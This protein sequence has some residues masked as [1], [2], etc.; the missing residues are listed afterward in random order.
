VTQHQTADAIPQILRAALVPSR[1]QLFFT[2]ICRLLVHT[3]LNSLYPHESSDKHEC[4]ATP[5]SSIMF[6]LAE[7]DVPHL[8]RSGKI[9]FCWL[10]PLPDMRGLA[11]DQGLNSRRQH[12]HFGDSMGHR[13]AARI[14]EVH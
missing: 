6:I 11:F 14:G 4:P 13:D 5:R 12:Q 3:A 8:D 7:P 9:R 10:A 1:R 2:V